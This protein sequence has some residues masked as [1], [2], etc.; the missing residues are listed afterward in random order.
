MNFFNARESK[1]PLRINAEFLFN[2]NNMKFS[3][4][5]EEI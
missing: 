2:P 4:D 1:N 5:D 3:K